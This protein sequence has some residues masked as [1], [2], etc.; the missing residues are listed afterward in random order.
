[1][2]VTLNR[3]ERSNAISTQMGRDLRDLFGGLYVRSE[4]IRCIV[5]TGSGSRAFCAGADLKERN[6]MTN[7]A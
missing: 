3:P 2:L 5:L 1:M 6:E 4:G 7:E